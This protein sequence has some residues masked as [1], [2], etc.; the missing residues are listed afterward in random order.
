MLAQRTVMFKSSG[1]AAAAK[2]AKVAA[3]S[4]REIIDLAA[5]EIWSDLAPSVREGA[6]AAIHCN[7]NRYTD[8]LGLMELR[9]ALARKISAET[10]QPWSADEIAVTSGA[11][12]ALFNAAMVLLNPGDEVLIPS[13]YWTTFPA[14]VVIAGGTPIFVRTRHNNY[15]PRLTDLAAAITPKTKAIVVN[16]PNNP[17]GTVYARDILAGIAKLAVDRDLWIIFDECYGSFVHAPHSHDPI[18]SVAPWARDR[19]LIVNSFSKSLALTGWRIGYLAGPNAVIEAVKA[20]QSHT[21][22]NPNVIAQHGLLHHL[23][24]RNPTFRLRLQ[25][26]VANARALGLSILSALTL[27]P[28]PAAQGGFYFYLDLGDLQRRAMANGRELD[29]DDVVK[30][31]LMNAGVAT[32]SGTAFGDP[33]GIRLSYGVDLESLDKGLRRLT[34][35]LNELAFCFA[36]HL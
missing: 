20:L 5:G 2:A 18:V 29:A 33:A 11:K 34:A 7:I 10:A 6:I 14:Q 24:T 30:A 32:V 17:T 15:V 21:T 35:T 8:T 25:R 19:T 16:T 27:V 31:L 28:Q 12:Q 22:S 13:P 26:H 23:G 4:G 3:A 1:T 36:R 9:H